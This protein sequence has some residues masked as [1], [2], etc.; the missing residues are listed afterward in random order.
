MQKL[1]IGFLGS[2]LGNLKNFGPMR[3]HISGT[4]AE[5][6]SEVCRILRPGVRL[7]K[8]INKGHGANSQPRQVLMGSRNCKASSLDPCL[9]SACRGV[10][11]PMFL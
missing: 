6:C 7:L 11:L 10:S 8:S 2:L 9:S 3:V 4:Q 1:K 5:V